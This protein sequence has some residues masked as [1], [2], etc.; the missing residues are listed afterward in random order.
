[1]THSSIVGNYKILSRVPYAIYNRLVFY[2]YFMYI[3]ASLYHR[4]I[5]EACE[6]VNFEHKQINCPR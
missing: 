6:A 3:C 4:V 5:K 2:I 1:M